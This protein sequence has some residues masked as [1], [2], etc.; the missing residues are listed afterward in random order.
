LLSRNRVYK[1]S[2]LNSVLGHFNP[3]LMSKPIS[4]NIYLN[5]IL[6]CLPGLFTFC[7]LF[8]ICYVA[9]FVFLAFLLYFSQITSLVNHG[10]W[11]TLYFTHLP[12]LSYI[13]CLSYCLYFDTG[14]D[15][16]ITETLIHIISQEQPKCCN[17]KLHIIFFLQN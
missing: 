3:V 7:I 11:H 12:T 17:A 16:G 6:R 15:P 8:K 5:V 4:F 10:P 13:L 9:F 2:S 14:V 1:I